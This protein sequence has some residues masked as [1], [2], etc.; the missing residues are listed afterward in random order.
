MILGRDSYDHAQELWGPRPPFEMSIFVLTNRPRPDD[1]RQGTTF[2]FVNEI[3]DDVFALATEAA[4]GKD[5]GLHGGGAI[6]QALRT[7]LLDELQLHVVPALVGA[8]GSSTGSGEMLR[9]LKSCAWRRARVG[10]V[11]NTGLL[12]LK[13]AHRLVGKEPAYGW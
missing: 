8:G 4:A 6:N 11:L 3:L 12:G 9:P 2:H 13:V 5:V 1:V 7:N 10:H